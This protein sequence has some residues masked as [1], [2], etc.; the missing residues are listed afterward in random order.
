M[1]IIYVAGP[2]RGD[3][4]ANIQRAREASI[5]L[6]GMGFYCITPHLNTGGFH[7]DGTAPEEVYLAGYLEIVKR[8]DAMV[9]LTGWQKS[10]GTRS[11]LELA[12]SL[13]LPVAEW[14]DIDTISQWHEPAESPQETE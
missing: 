13:G 8:C 14:P 12:E 1:K 2:Y 5:R 4:A 7:I 9:L 6:W 11:E 3:T 10:S